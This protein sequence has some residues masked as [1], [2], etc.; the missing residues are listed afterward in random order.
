MVGAFNDE[1]TDLLR[2]ARKILDDIAG[3]GDFA[4]TDEAGKRFREGYSKG[5][6]KAG[7]YTGKL[8]AV[9]SEIADRL[10]SMKTAVDIA[11]WATVQ[12]LPKVSDPPKFSPP[13]GT[14]S[15]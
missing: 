2:D 3:L 6:E 15:S 5:L 7:N 8:G 12:A 10:A 1:H 9:Y 13:D 11:N 4:G 14:I